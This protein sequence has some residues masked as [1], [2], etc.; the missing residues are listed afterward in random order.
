MEEKEIIE[1]L[2]TLPDDKFRS[3][4]A[5]VYIKEGETIQQ[6]Q[7][8]K[9]RMLST[10]DNHIYKEHDG[11]FKPRFDT[12]M[13]YDALSY[14]LANEAPPI[15]VF[16]YVQEV[17]NKDDDW[18]KVAKHTQISDKSI[19]EVT[20]ELFKESYDIV[21]RAKENGL[22]I[23]DVVRKSK[24][25]SQQIRGIHKHITLSDRVDALEAKVA[26]LDIRQKISE[27]KVDQIENQLSLQIDPNRAIAIRLKLEGYSQK[28]I[29]EELGVTT[30]TL[31]NWF[32]QI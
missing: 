24:T 19:K 16:E 29:S 4:V 15:Q 8:K 28:E 22:S 26:E 2:K 6:Q 13:L 27:M 30:R 3:M 18:M 21:D 32:K 14:Q 23:K 9:N 1:Y 5:E 25:P 20:K 12:T 17:Y 31:R 11:T 10:I 7:T